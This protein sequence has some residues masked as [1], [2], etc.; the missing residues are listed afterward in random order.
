MILY[1][2]YFR[3]YR[4]YSLPNESLTNE[5]PHEKRDCDM[6]FKEQNSMALNAS[7]SHS[8]VSTFASQGTSE[9]Q[10]TIGVPIIQGMIIL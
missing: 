2:S 8:L 10:Q 3:R 9:S 5:K 6:H 1:M 7:K 4:Q